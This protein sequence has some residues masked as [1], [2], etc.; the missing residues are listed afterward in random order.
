MGWPSRHSLLCPGPKAMSSPEMN[1]VPLEKKFCSL[2]CPCF[3]QPPQ[4]L[5]QLFICIWRGGCGS[6]SVLGISTD[7]LCVDQ[8]CFLT[9]LCC[10]ATLLL[11]LL[12]LSQKVLALVRNLYI[13]DQNNTSFI[14]RS[15][16]PSGTTGPVL[17]FLSS[18]QH[19]CRFV[20][21]YFFLT[22]LK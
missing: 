8:V 6:A 19:N 7:F 1:H 2:S 5:P 10:V 13:F 22:Q 14:F 18:V 15:L 3:P 21:A 4:G 20:R 16:R 9:P 17:S 12:H 11:L